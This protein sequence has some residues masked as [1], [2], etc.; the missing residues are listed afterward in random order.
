[1]RG[2]VVGNEKTADS[3]RTAAFR[4]GDEPLFAATVGALEVVATWR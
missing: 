3:S 2:S 4:V 1:M